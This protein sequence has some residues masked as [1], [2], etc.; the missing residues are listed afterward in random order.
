MFILWLALK[1]DHFQD[2]KNFHSDLKHF[3]RIYFRELHFRH[4]ARI[5]FR[6]LQNFAH[7]ARTYF[8]EFQI[9]ENFENVYFA[10]SMKNSLFTEFQKFSWWF[11]GFREDLFSRITQSDKFPEDLFS[12][13]F[14][15]RENKCSRKLMP[16]KINPREN[17]S[18]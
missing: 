7:F 17:L 12:R 2:F 16:A 14:S 13:F 11:K 9:L 5:Y 4:F 3:A 6:E 10:I 15:I 1:I 8:R 18:L